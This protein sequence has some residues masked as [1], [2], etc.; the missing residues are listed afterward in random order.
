VLSALYLSFMYKLLKFSK[1]IKSNRKNK[2]K[3]KCEVRR[4]NSSELSAQKELNQIIR[5][6]SAVK[7]PSSNISPINIANSKKQ[8][9]SEY[10]KNA[11]LKRK[12]LK[13]NIQVTV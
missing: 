11:Y 5:V 6:S 13:T 8:K 9:K 2:Y 4:S 10:N 3:R 12:A 1:P 7:R